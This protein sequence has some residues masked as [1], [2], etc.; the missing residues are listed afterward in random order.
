MTTQPLVIDSTRPPLVAWLRRMW[1]LNWPLTLS[2]LL[3]IALIPIY[4]VAAIADPRIITG[5]P[6]FVKPLKFVLSFAIYITTFLW[7]LSLVKGPRWILGTLG[8]VT[9]LGALVEVVLITLQA[10]RG[11]TS[12]YNLATPF[13]KMVFD[14][15]GMFIV[16]VIS[17]NLGLG[18]LLL[19]QKQLERTTAW[20]IRL[21]VLITFVGMMTGFLMTANPSEA[22]LAQRAAGERPSTFGGHSVGVEDG[23]PGLPLLGWSTQG[24][25]LRVAHFFGLHGMQALPL[26][27]FALGLPALRRRTR[28]GQ[29]TAAILIVGLAYL[30][31]VGLLTWQALRGQPAL[32]PDATTLLAYAALLGTAGGAL[33]ITFWPRPQMPLPAAKTLG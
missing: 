19:F 30:G 5:A 23:G 32:A 6:A 27:A 10:V 18:I 24:G 14:I 4:V 25:D 29:R 2:V 1:A 28:P 33:A 21:S 31:W 15:M 17:M 11:T 16:L 9:A 20:A 12:H 26:F 13:D 8:F 22:Q 3:Y 7:L